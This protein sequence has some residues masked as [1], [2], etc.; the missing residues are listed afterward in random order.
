MNTA[1]EA[2]DKLRDTAMSHE[3][4]S[5]IEVMGRKA[6]Y[7]A[8]NVGIACGAEVV[9]IPE[10]ET[11]FT[12]DVVKVLLQGRNSGKHH[13][14]VVVAEGAGSATDVA[15]KI[16]AIT[17]IESR[18]TILGHLQRGGSPTNRDRTMASMM[19]LRAIECIR[20]GCLNRII[21]YKA[22]ELVDFEIE[23]ALSMTKTIAAVE[24]ERAH[25]LA[26]R[27]AP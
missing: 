18:A 26:A 15:A 19:G 20:Q 16:E 9:M 3:R 5:V 11:D 27:R 13:Y 8:L 25:I 10:V 22:G 14:I 12:R 17:G 2:I 4:C 21:A 7:L 23:E 6:G 1:M 24:I